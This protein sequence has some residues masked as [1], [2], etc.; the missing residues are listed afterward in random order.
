[1]RNNYREQLFSYTGPAS[2]G[3]VF[4]RFEFNS[5]LQRMSAISSSSTA[6]NTAFVYTKGAPEAML[7]IMRKESVPSDYLKV[8]EKY[9]SCGFRVLAIASK[10]VQTGQIGSIQRDEA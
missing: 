7:K 9:T 2:S 1:M 8:Q 6:P 3:T 4:R 10:E 5:E